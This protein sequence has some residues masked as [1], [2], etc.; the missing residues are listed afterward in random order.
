MQ[1]CPKCNS[2]NIYEA[3][4]SQPKV[5]ISLQCGVCNDCDHNYTR[6]YV[7]GEEQ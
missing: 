2:T 6:L 3:E 7:N 1:R 5:A 4:R